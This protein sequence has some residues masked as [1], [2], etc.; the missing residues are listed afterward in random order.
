[1]NKNLESLIGLIE[2]ISLIILDGFQ[3]SSK[4]VE[5]KISPLKLYK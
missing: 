2:R 3:H 5:I 4:E 1:M